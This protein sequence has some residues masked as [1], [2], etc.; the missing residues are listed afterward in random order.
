MNQYNVWN[1]WGKL[2]TVML[3][4]SYSSNFFRDIKNSRIRGALQR[5]ADETQE[6]LSYYE[7]VLKDFGCTVLRPNLDKNDSIWISS[8]KECKK[9]TSPE[10]GNVGVID[11]GFD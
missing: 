1:K 5:I 4:E 11:H 6:D 9:T 3:G 2:K 7:S 10:R 8:G